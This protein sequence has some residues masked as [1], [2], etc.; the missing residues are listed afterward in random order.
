MPLGGG[1]LDQGRPEGRHSSAKTSPG[2]SRTPPGASTTSGKSAG[3]PPGDPRLSPA[4][5]EVPLDASEIP[6]GAPGTPPVPSKIAPRAPEIPPGTWEIA[7]DKVSP[8][9]SAGAESLPACV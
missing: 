1:G 2:V 9:A 6:P 8:E 5:S 7:P 4:A 3:A